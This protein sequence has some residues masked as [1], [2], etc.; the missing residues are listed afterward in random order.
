MQVVAA[1][2]QRQG[3]LSGRRGARG[4]WQ[5]HPAYVG[6]QRSDG[7]PAIGIVPEPGQPGDCEYDAIECVG[8]I[9][10][11]VDS[12]QPRIDGATQRQ[13][14]QTRPHARVR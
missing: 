3:T 10:A 7:R 8:M 1:A 2:F 11:D 13:K 5:D 4:R 14:P 9:R 6:K 12:T